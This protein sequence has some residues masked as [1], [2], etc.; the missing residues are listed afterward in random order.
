LAA[1]GLQRQ[2]GFC[3]Q[4][5][6]QRR[7]WAGGWPARWPKANA[8]VQHDGLPFCQYSAMMALAVVLDSM[9]LTQIGTMPMARKA[10]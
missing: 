6:R 10:T 2:A 4:V 8:H 1:L 7:R 5:F 3:F 9:R